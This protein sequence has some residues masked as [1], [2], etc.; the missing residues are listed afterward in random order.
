MAVG[1]KL[2][3]TREPVD[4]QVSFFFLRPVA[5]DAVFLKEPLERFRGADGAGEGEDGQAET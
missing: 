1:A 3:I 5:T 2:E 4:A